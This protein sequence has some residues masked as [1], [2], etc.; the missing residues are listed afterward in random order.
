MF[1]LLSKLLYF[2]LAP[3]TWI[4]VLLVL[5]WFI[6]A[7][8]MKKKYLISAIVLLFLFTNTF[9][10]ETAVKA[11][12]PAQ[13]EIPS[14]TSYDAG[15]LLGGMSGYDK[16]GKGVFN[17]ASDRFIQAVKL[18]YSGI[19]RKIIVSG[20]A[21]Q[22]RKSFPEAPFLRQ[23]LIA[24][25]VKENDIIIE[26]Q[27]RNTA[28]NGFY[29]RQLIDTLHIRMPVVL[30]TS[31]IHMPRAASVFKKAGVQFVPFPCNY[32]VIDSRVEIK[33]LIIPSPRLLDEWTF[34]IK[35][36]VGITIYKL[37]GKA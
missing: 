29:T 30:I 32:S 2:L 27:S 1:F 25:G 11:Y 4:V 36:I 7:T 21:G 31:A 24:S 12:Q 6:P 10:Y 8:R 18:Y 22:L 34:F 9:I 28:E 19:I 14:G 15:V 13:K 20:G 16:F 5:Y 37:T 35:E 3:L 33:D 26:A 23:E 17:T